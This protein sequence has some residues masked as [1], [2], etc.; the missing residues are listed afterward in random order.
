MHHTEKVRQWVWNDTF[1]SAS[2]FQW[3]WKC[4]KTAFHRFIVQREIGLLWSQLQLFPFYRTYFK[5]QAQQRLMRR[6]ETEYIYRGKSMWFVKS[7]A[8]EALRS[9]GIH[10]ELLP[11]RGI[12]VHKDFSSWP[13]INHDNGLISHIYTQHTNREKRTLTILHREEETIESPSPLPT[14]WTRDTDDTQK[15]NYKARKKQ[16]QAHY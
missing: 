12:L 1:L 7:L 10:S 9:F 11:Q 13:I 3:S 6:V 8:P 4:K 14:K 16:V 15:K 2:L 5:G